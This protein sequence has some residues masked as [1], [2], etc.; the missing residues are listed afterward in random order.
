MQEPGLGGRAG[1][2]DVLEVAGLV[3]CDLLDGEPVA[4]AGDQDRDVDDERDELLR[5][6]PE[7]RHVLFERPHVGRRVLF[8]ARVSFAFGALQGR[9]LVEG[10]IDVVGALLSVDDAWAE[11]LDAVRPADQVLGRRFGEGL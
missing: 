5:H 9:V 11:G 6:G 2:D 7:G 3:V 4:G 1:L 8:E 10:A